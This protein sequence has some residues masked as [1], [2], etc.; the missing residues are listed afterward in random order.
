MFQVARQLRFIKWMS[1]YSKTLRKAKWYLVGCC[2]IF[3]HIT[4]GYA[5]LGFLVSTEFQPE[6]VATRLTTE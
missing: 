2:F 5:G 1:R 4:V 3:T 6:I